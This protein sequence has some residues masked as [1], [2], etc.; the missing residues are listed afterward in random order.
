MRG[1]LAQAVSRREVRPD[2]VRFDQPM[3]GHAHC[4]NRRLR[5]LGEQQPLLR[6]LEAE[7][8]QRL[9]ERIVCFREHLA[10]NREIIG[11]RLPHPDF[12]RSLARKNE[13]DHAS[14]SSSPWLTARVAIVTA[15]RTAFADE[16]PC[17]TMQ[18]PLTPSSG[19]P[20]Y[21]E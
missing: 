10:T 4:Q 2:P 21:S 14:F 6:P 18:I 5:V 8:A 11:Q 3:H 13:R 7:R 17:P 15:L 12:L 20:P 9:A 19:A 16:R 1:V